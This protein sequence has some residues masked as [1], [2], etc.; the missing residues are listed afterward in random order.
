MVWRCLRVGIRHPNLLTFYGA[1]IMSRTS[2]WL[3]MPAAA[4]VDSRRLLIVFLVCDPTVN[5]PL[6]VCSV[7]PFVGRCF[8][9][10]ALCTHAYV[11][12]W[13]SSSNFVDNH[14]QMYRVST[15]GNQKKHFQYRS[16]YGSLY[17]F[18]IVAFGTILPARYYVIGLDTLLL[19]I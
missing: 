1:G 10:R 5:I 8:A 19:C 9:L 3:P 11:Q 13:F 6:E 12:L 16:V 14:T 18:A 4:H 7:F 15:M 17:I 2:T